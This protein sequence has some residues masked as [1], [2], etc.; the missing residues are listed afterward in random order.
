MK[1]SEDL[2]KMFSDYIWKPLNLTEHD[3]FI[4]SAGNISWNE[5]SNIDDLMNEDGE[6]YSAYIYEQ[7]D[8]DG[9]MLVTISDDCGGKNQAFFDK[10]REIDAEEYWKVVNE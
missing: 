9:Y 2:I 3:W 8:V 7:V 4:D 6:T 10:M 5:E 1:S